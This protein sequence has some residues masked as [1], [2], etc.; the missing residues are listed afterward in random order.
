MAVCSF[1][2]IDRQLG[3]VAV[4]PAAETWKMNTPK[5]PTDTSR[6]REVIFHGQ[7]PAKPSSSLTKP[8]WPNQ[9]EGRK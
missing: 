3:R 7:V 6:V 2:A 8:F 9:E 5:K 4:L 1:L